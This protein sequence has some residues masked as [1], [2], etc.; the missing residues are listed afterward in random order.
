MR[1]FGLGPVELVICCL[2]LV[3]VVIVALVLGLGR[4]GQSSGP[5]GG[6]AIPPANVPAGWYADPTHRHQSRYWDGSRWTE[7]VADSGVSA[8]DPL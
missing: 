8:T 1:I 7:H 6:Q 4:S 5:P 2:P 3:A